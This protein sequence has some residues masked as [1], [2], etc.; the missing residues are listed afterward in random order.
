LLATLAEAGFVR[1][2]PATGRY[3]L[4]FAALEIA[5]LVLLQ[6][7]IREAAQPVMRE[8]ALRGGETANLAILDGQEAVIVEQAPSPQPC[9]VVSWV[10]RRVP[11]HATA[12]GRVLLT[13]RPQPEREELLA[14]LADSAGVLPPWSEKAPHTLAELR[15]IIA[16]TAARGYALAQGELDREVAGVAAPVYNHLGAVVASLSLSGPTYRYEPAHVAA[17]AALLVEGTRRISAELGWRPEAHANL[18][19]ASPQSTKGVAS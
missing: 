5:G 6:L 2:N 17:L 10:G 1:V 11:L 14:A 12:H 18:A 7:D 16:A 19:V 9:R 8:L 4:G 13:F 15:Q 3:R